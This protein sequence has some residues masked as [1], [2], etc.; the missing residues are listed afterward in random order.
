M[1]NVSIRE[2]SFNVDAEKILR[3][4]SYDFQPNAIT[5]I[6]APVEERISFLL[7][8]ICGICEPA[9]GSV[10]IN[11]VDLYNTPEK[12]LEDI[13]RSIAYCFGRGGLL[14]NLSIQQNLLLPFDYHYPKIPRAEKLEKVKSLFRKLDVHES[15]LNERPAMLH[16]QMY[17]MMVLI[18]TFLLDP[19]I[20]LYDNPFLD[21]EKH[22][23]KLVYAYI[24]ELRG[25]GKTTQIFVSTSD[26]LFELSDQILVFNHG[27]FIEA[28]GWDELLMSGTETTQNLIR[29]YLEAGVGM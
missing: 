10:L 25:T 20:I 23:Q 16:P 13:R 3:E 5:G 7:K 1:S 8:L 24:H 11:G 18:R 21:L 15:L 14:S 26:I 29:Q 28:G 2:L 12:E 9:S 6:L 22:Y 19:A 17:K 4:V 27:R